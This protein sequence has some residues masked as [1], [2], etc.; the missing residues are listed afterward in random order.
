MKAAVHLILLAA[1]SSLN[2]GAVSPIAKVLQLLTDLEAKVTSEGEEA[3]KMH[4][5]LETMCKDRTTDLG[6]DIRTGKS[7]V[8]ELKGAIEKQSATISSLNARVGELAEGIA[9]DEADLKAASE[10][11]TKEKADSVAESTELEEII[12]ML[13]RAIGVLEREMRKGGAAMLQFKNARTVTQALTAMVQAS[14][15]NSADAGRLSSLLQSSQIVE[16]NDDDMS[17]GAPDAAV[18]ASHSGGIVD[19]LQDLLE[20][21]Q[22]QLD[23]ARKKEVTAANNFAML[24]QSLTDEVKFANKD[25][26]EAKRGIAESQQGK[27]GAEGDLGVTSKDL[28]RDEAA[29]ASLEEKCATRAE[30]FDAASKSRAEELKALGEAKKIIADSTGGA[31]EVSYSFIQVARSEISTSVDLAHFEAVRFVRDLARKQDSPAL[32]QLASQMAAVMRTSSNSGADPFAK[33][34]NLITDLIK[35]LEATAS[36]DS[37]QKAYCDKELA[38]SETKKG[39]KT[40]EIEKLST[41]IDQMTARSAQLKVEV[42]ALQKSLAQIASTQA[43]AGQLRREE[44]SAFTS[45]KADVEQGIQGVRLALKVLREYYNSGDAAHAAAKGAGDSIVGLLEVVE[46]DFTRGLAELTTAEDDA[47]AVFDQQTQMNKLET[48]QKEQDVKYKAKESTGL[49]KA[50]AEAT[51]DRASEQSELDAVLEYLGKLK[52]QCVAK[53]ETYSEKAGRRDAE[54][55]GLKQALSILEGEAVFL[56]QTARRNLRTSHARWA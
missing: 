37:T 24:K 50:V 44:S 14:V 12:S 19:T 40:Y 16:A 8:A 47:Q 43:E 56:Q 42:A 23:A 3:S 29:L 53:A 36:A 39:E 2:V 52:E 32:A 20:K 41:K 1:L 34:K 51:S 5:E 45:N 48:A 26:G 6:F 10:I 27:A 7:E 46:S 35:R 38:E 11:R 18:Y 49:D 21:A 28:S 22:T 31:A 33:V 13:G 4:A 15:L 55:S 25:M 17:L 9:S 54:I 30:D